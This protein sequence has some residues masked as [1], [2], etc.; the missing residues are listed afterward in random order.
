MILRAAW[1]A[2]RERRDRLGLALAAL[3]VAATLSTALLGLYAD[4]ET[5]LRGEF[6][7]YGANLVLAPAGE[8]ETVPIALLADADRW[9][10]A[11]PFLYRV[12]TVEGEPV[13]IAE[14]DFAR[15]EP[16]A[17]YW[18]VQGRRTARPGECLVGERVAEKFHVGV[19]GVLRGRRVAG[20][21]AT[22]GPEDSQIIVPLGPTSAASWIGVRVEGPRVE[23]ARRALAGPD[24]EARVLRAVVDSGAAVVLKI[25]GTLFL[26]SALVLA[27]SGLCVMNNFS[28]MVYQRRKE[29][30]ILKAI[31]GADARIAALFTAE[32]AGL[33]AL[34]GLAG[35]GIGSLVA[36]WMG[37]EIFRRPA[38]VGVETLA[39]V[40]AIT[41]AVALVATAVPLRRI[42]RIE[43][44]VILRGE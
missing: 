4:I 11:A 33:G 36:R 44:A 34:G 41:L 32:A 7:G 3:T 5:K 24:V 29:I 17:S 15:L 38:D 40:L 14:V 20:V 26:L 10:K 42:R 1:K 8:A 6:A 12:E 13:V 22:G 28:A 23:E 25:R 2:M 35:F 39:A 27:I 19:D 43:P 9:G 18:Q 16:L 37:R 30:G 21:V 31:G